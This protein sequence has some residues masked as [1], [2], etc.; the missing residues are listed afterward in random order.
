MIILLDYIIEELQHPFK[1][2]REY[3]SPTKL[4]ITNP[5]LFYMLIDESERT[6]KRGLIV[7]ATVIRVYDNMVLC[8][9]DNGLDATIQKADLEKTDEK[10]QDIIE[11]GHVI[12]GRIHEIKDKEEAKFGVN[13]N[14]KRKDLESHKNYVDKKINVH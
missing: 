11:V 1:D 12:T 5:Q 13:L 8:K 4:L 14:C 10:L 2:P 6:L 3:R 9:L 7:T